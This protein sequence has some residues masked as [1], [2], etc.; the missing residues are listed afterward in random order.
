M[1]IRH[2]LN[3][4][5]ILL[6]SVFVTPSAF[7][8]AS[9]FN[10]DKVTFCSDGEFDWDSGQSL[11]DFVILSREDG[12]FLISFLG[13]PHPSFEARAF[14][15]AWIKMK[16]LFS[17]RKTR[18]DIFQSLDLSYELSIDVEGQSPRIAK[19]NVDK[20]GAYTFNVEPALV[21]EGITTKGLCWDSL[22]REPDAIRRKSMQRR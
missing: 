4:S 21:L 16:G 7:A 9:V 14:D 19:L 15:N 10:A 11:Y 12:D 1:K 17:A 20:T 13:I 5:V 2:Y 22:S 6:L 3:L 8:Q 18:G